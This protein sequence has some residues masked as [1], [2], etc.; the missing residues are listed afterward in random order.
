MSLLSV[1]SRRW[2]PIGTVCAIALVASCA[3]QASGSPGPGPT[4][5]AESM[6]AARISE[7]GANAPLPRGWSGKIINRAPTKRRVVALT[8]DC[9]S[10]GAGVP[11]ILTTLRKT[12][13][14]A[15]FFVT[16][17]FAR[18]NA[19]TVRKIVADGHLVGNHSDTHA[20]FTGLSPAGQT[21]QLRKAE[22]SITADT[23]SSP[24][25]WFRFPYG[26]SNSSAVRQVN[27]GG[28]ATIGWT[29]DSLG[30]LGTSTGQSAASVTRRVVGAAQPGEIALMHCGSNPNDRSTLD[31]NA[32]PAVIR[33]LTNKGFGF[34]T[35]GEL[36][37]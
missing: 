34:A 30:W 35:L 6:T 33:G 37:R 14:R 12:N 25:P 27:R 23:G 4:V 22:R 10:N 7:P 5:A 19:K 24:R 36:V 21:A 1:A 18:S 2:V 8:F 16:G 28:Y 29:V 32:L 20:N 31:A 15:T 26:A 3:A 9:G 13:T 11:S 17:Q